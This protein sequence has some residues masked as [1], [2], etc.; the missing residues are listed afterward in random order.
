[1]AKSFQIAGKALRD[2]PP[3]PGERFPLVIVS[4][5]YPG[6]RTFLTYLTE[7]LASK[8]YV[9]A[10]IDHTDSVFGEVR[11]FSSTLL[12]RARDQLFT[13]AALEQVPFLRGFLDATRVAIV[14]YSMG[15]YGALASA[16]A[17]YSKQGGAAR[18]VPGG[19]FEPLTAG[20]LKAPVSLKAIVAIAP[21][22]AQPP[23]NGF[24]VGVERATLPAIGRVRSGDSVAAEHPGV[25]V[26]FCQQRSRNLARLPSCAMDGYAD[27]LERSHPPRRSGSGGILLPRRR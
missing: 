23:N 24:G 13:I 6:S 1:V 12:N 7:N 10:A 22:G 11:A 21:W 9:V 25:P 17:P 26:Q 19:Y 18:L 2:A 4:H 14:G 5:G 8:G 20:N 27:V 16:G 3:A 15:G